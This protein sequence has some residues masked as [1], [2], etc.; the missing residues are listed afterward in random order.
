MK[1]RVLT[2]YTP[3]NQ[4]IYDWD[5]MLQINP[6]TQSGQWYEM[7]YMESFK[8]SEAAL[9]VL[10][11]RTCAK[12]GLRAEIHHTTVERTR[13]GRKTQVPALRFR[14]LPKED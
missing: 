10:I 11:R 6:K 12:R 5:E 8:C 1:G 13:A 2:H 4:R 9:D 14:A 3:P 7:V